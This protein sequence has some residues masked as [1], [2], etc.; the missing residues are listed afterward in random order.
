VKNVVILGSGSDGGVSGEGKGGAGDGKNEGGGG[1]GGRAGHDQQPVEALLSCA[2]QFR[3]PFSLTDSLS[4]RSRT[5][6]IS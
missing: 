5:P 1:R 6:T 4:P 3:E 2:G